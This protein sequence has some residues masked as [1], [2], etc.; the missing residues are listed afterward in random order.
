MP[1]FHIVILAVVQGITEFL[2][3]SSSAH[4]ILA[5][6]MLGSEGLETDRLID[7]GVHVGT[8]FAVLL[9]FRKD[10]YRML[11]GCV[12]AAGQ[13]HGGGRVLAGKIML[14]SVP[15]LAAGFALHVF[16]PEWMRSLEVIG[17]FALVFGIVLWYAD[18][19]RPA[20]REISSLGWRDALFVGLAQA[21]A[22]I[23][24]T[25]RSGITMTAGRWLGLSRTESARFSFLLALVAISGAGA[26]GVIDVLKAES[27]G[28]A[29]DFLT[30]AAV[31]F[32]ASYAALVGLMKW[33]ARA[34]FTPFVVYR[35]LLGVI[36]LALIYSGVI[37]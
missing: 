37:S 9:Y 35:V 8:L 22:L 18:R 27:P 23:P 3:I 16:Q 20:D 4:L 13:D 15:A 36:L 14:A 26:L 34:T 30:A 28:L 32:V 7:I 1:F 5:H 17:W 6:E 31:S 25:S 24:G 12:A 19:Y 33:L 10:L 2:P 29:L 21:V 11:R